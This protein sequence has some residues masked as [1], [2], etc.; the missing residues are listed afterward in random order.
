MRWSKLKQQVESL[1]AEPL[2]GRVQLWTTRYEKAHDR[3]GRSWITFDGREVASMSNDLKC[4]NGIAD[5]N[6]VRFQEG[7]F[8]GYDLP[9]AMRQYLSLSINRA[10]ASPHPLI[11][12]LAALDRRVGAGRLA[13]LNTAET[14]PVVTKL[15]EIRMMSGSVTG[16]G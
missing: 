3:T 4:S 7:V 15:I 8:A 6:P 1:F 9:D 10:L 16:N 5:G 14:N 11:R 13:R 12:G 2:R